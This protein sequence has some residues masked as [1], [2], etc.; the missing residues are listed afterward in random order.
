MSDQQTT[1]AVQWLD[2][3]EAIITI[4]VAGF[5]LGLPRPKRYR[6]SCTVWHDAETGA[7][8]GSGR[9]ARLAD[10]WTKAKWERA[11]V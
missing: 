4:S 2:G 1:P 3:D 9:E 5:F 6:G 8:A 7:R 11:N 10:I